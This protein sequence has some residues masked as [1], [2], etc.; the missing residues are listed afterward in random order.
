MNGIK[1]TKRKHFYQMIGEISGSD[2]YLVVGRQDI[3]KVEKRIEEIA[4]GFDEYRYLLTI[5]GFGPYIFSVVLSAIAAPFRR[6]RL[7]TLRH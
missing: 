4:Q 1:D 5:P 6:A 2:E 3:G 7:R